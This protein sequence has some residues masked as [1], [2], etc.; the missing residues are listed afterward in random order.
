MRWI[1]ATI[2]TSSTE[3]D[4]LCD[5]LTEL[6]VEGVFIEDEKD[7]RDFLENNRQY[8]DYVD[9]ELDARFTGLARVKFYLP[10]DEECK[11]RLI[12]IKNEL[13]INPDIK[14]VNDADWEDNWKQY[15]RPLEIGERLL[16][17]PEW[18]RTE[19]R[20]RVPIILDPGLAF[21]TG[22]HA[23]TRMCLCAME[24]L[25]LDGNTVLDL[26]CGSGILGIG[27]VRLGA[28]FVAGC[29]IDP[30]APDIAKENARLNNIGGD[31]FR[32][33]AGD[34]L[35]D[36]SLR[37]EL[38]GGYELVLAN[39]VADVIIPLCAVVRRFMAPHG[40][41]IC[42]GII[43]GRQREVETALEASGLKIVSHAC[44]EEWHCYHAALR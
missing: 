10:E 9:E 11:K 35:E 33:Y 1:E 31:R 25:E 19:A 26:G 4:P 36:E 44:E 22:S 15:Y 43:E 39:I 34:I 3:I 7:F 13:Q 40:A 30:K 42:S 37:R 17:V 27:A 32:L 14:I 16:V 6:G 41:F 5:K 12:D 8:W 38:S 20:G 2:E 24:K 18:E 29:D 23:T 21:G 28:K